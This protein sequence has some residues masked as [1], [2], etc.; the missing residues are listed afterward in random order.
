MRG[1]GSGICAVLLPLGLL[2]GLGQTIHAARPDPGAA[3]WP[4]RLDSAAVEP[5]HAVAE[6]RSALAAGAPLPAPRPALVV[7]VLTL[8]I[9]DPWRPVPL[10]LR[11]PAESGTPRPHDVAIG[12]YGSVLRAYAQAESRASTEPRSDRL[13]ELDFTVGISEHYAYVAA[14]EAGL[15]ILDYTASASE[16]REYLLATPGAAEAVVVSGQRAHVA[17]VQHVPAYSGYD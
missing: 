9:S 11:P 13:S 17:V 7:R 5:Q 1:F 10:A 6:L 3:T 12:D 4:T 15:R 16:R 2:L 8:D 14:G